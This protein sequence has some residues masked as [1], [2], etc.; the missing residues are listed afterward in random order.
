MIHERKFLPCIAALVLLG[1]SA[2]NA[3]D[4][5]AFD[6][7]GLYVG[8]GPS[9]QYNVLGDEIEDAIGDELT[10]GDVAIGG[11]DLDESF[12]LNATIG[13][14]LA[15]FF[16]LEIEYEWIDQYDIGASGQFDVPPV[17]S[18][19]GTLYSIGG[20][21][22]TANTRWILPIWRIQPYFLLGG[23]FALSDTDRGDL[24]DTYAPLLLAEGIDID[25]GDDLAGAGRLGIGFDWCITQHLVLNTEAGIV[26][27]TLKAPDI[28]D[29]ED[30]NYLSFQMGLQYKF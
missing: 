20:H 25:E 2:A 27:T 15:S 28:E 4:T 11:L 17:V 23:G 6:R 13:Y 22:L 18:A 9:F 16:A 10:S 21:T 30:L 14:R 12:G 24:Y 3:G 1:T 5:D 29:I 19:S 26:V 7:P 8:L